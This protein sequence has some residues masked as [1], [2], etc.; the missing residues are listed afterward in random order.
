MTETGA[1]FKGKAKAP[2]F[3]KPAPEP[4]SKSTQEKHWPLLIGGALA[5]AGILLYL[6]SKQSGSVG[7]T[8]VLSVAANPSADISQ[9][10]NMNNTIQEMLANP[11]L[12][13]QSTTGQTVSSSP[14]PDSQQSV[15][16]PSTFTPPPTSNSAN[17]YMTAGPAGGI[18]TQGAWDPM[19]GISQAAWMAN[20]IPIN[21]NVTYDV[22]SGKMVPYNDPSGQ[23]IQARSSPILPPPPN[24]FS[25]PAAKS[26]GITSAADW[27]KLAAAN[28]GQY[29]PIPT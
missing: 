13:Q 12:W 23:N 15:P 20:N 17:G 21:Q 3:Y 8:P 14:T 10:Q 25:T 24:W 7:T 9:L 19:T 29:I 28:P 22:A 2:S 5:G 1:D 27:N 11:Q 26:V 4:R 16:P 18:P 6:R